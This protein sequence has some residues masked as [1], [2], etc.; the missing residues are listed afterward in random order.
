M[1]SAAAV[2]ARQ[3]GSRR[4]PEY[5]SSAKLRAL[6]DLSTA[7]SA[8]ASN[9]SALPSSIASCASESPAVNKRLFTSLAS[10][11]GAQRTEQSHRIAERR[12]HRQR[13]FVGV[14]VAAD[15]DQQAALGGRYWP[16][17][18]TGA[19]ITDDPDGGERLGRGSTQLSGWM[20]LWIATSAPGRRPAATPSGRSITSCT[21]WSSTTQ[22]A[23]MS[24]SD[25]EV[26]REIAAR[27]G[28][29]WRRRARASR[30]AA[31]TAPLGS[32][33]R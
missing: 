9:P 32:R 26:R 4:R 22:M 28:R 20:V 31:P 17:P 8:S 10:W 1:P 5:V 13:S 12:E 24:A 11:P 29:G 19:S 23:T 15:H 18:L 30:R 33:P 21:S 14:L 27:P 2:P 6:P 7:A 16:P 3:A 25:G